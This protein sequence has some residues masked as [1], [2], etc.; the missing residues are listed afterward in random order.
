MT[1][2]PAFV[3][4][5]PSPSAADRALRRSRAL[6]EAGLPTPAVLAR[7]GPQALCFQRIAPAGPLPDLAGMLR[8]LEQLNGIPNCGLPRFDPFL[9][10]RPRLHRAPGGLASL[11]Q[12]LHARLDATAAR[13]PAVV[14][15]DFHPGQVLRDGAGHLWLVDLDDMALAP[16]EADLGNLAAWMATQAIGPLADSA[17]M[18]RHAILRHVQGAEA[19]LVALFC[20]I[21]L[22]R[23]ALKLAERGEGWALDQLALLA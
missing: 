16:R 7:I 10:I 8:L 12:R 15:G 19:G 11:A 14:H 23:R 1:L 17:A 18:A 6:A 13:A 21:A 9:R 4:H 3:K 20:D 22:L 5:Y 2:P